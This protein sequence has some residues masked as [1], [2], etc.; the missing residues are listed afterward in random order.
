VA[1]KLK[2]FFSERIVRSI[3][4]DVHRVHPAF[5]ERG[6]VGACMTGL[7]SLELTARAWHVADALYDR[8]PRPFAAAAEI[9]V[10]SLGPELSRSDTFCMAPFRYLPHVFFVQK[11]GLDDF[12]AAM[13][14]QYELTKRFSAESTS[15]AGSKCGERML[16][17]LE[18][19]AHWPEVTA[20]GRCR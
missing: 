1:E 18:S 16:P 10:A 13:R 14:G 19:S 12:E 5:G 20:S 4:S 6:F 9:L 7:S 3:A 2:H 17:R 11:H 15:F 8:L